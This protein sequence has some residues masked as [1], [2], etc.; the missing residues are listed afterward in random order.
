MGHVQKMNTAPT[1]PTNYQNKLQIQ[2]G[3]DRVL[4]SQA[5]SQEQKNRAPPAAFWSKCAAM[6]F[7]SVK[8]KST[9]TFEVSLV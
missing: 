7:N 9:W 3:S 5:K 8:A 2:S 4:A 6:A 1:T